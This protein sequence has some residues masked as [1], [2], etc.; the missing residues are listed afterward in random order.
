MRV[1]V[2]LALTLPLPAAL[3][4]R[5]L[6]ARLDPRMAT[7][8]LTIA[9]VGFAGAS[10]LALTALAATEVGQIP[11]LASVGDWSV[12]VLR[13]D[14]P[15]ST[16]EALVACVLL[17]VVLAAAGRALVR[18]V[19]ALVAAAR[20]AHRLP[21]DPATRVVIL[22]DEVP[23]AYAMPGLPGRIVV[24]TGMLDALDEPERRVLLAHERAHLSCGHHVFVTVAY[25]AAVTNPLL[26]PLAAAVRY[27]SE[28]WADE[29]AAREVGD[30]RLV[31]RT[32]GKAALLTRRRPAAPAVAL[33]IATG[34][35]ARLRGAGPVPRRVAALLAA[36]PPR[37]RLLLAVVLGVVALAVLSSAETVRDLHA[38][39]ELA[40]AGKP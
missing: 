39:F 13:R 29:R 15:A 16:T 27:T 12:R 2:Y 21:V 3:S 5:W 23:D 40:Q 22:D 26:W 4:A 33:G 8:L 36:P 24:S 37:R 10:G 32:I 1:A 35:M 34:A 9:T 7:W 17:V 30:R 20:T 18:R 11:L 31:A 28:R 14:D 6:A 25:L 19:R 38:L